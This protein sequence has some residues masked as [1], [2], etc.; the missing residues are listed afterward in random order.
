[1][2]TQ[3]ARRLF[4]GSGFNPRQNESQAVE[5][6]AEAYLISS[7]GDLVNG[8]FVN[9]GIAFGS[10]QLQT[11]STLSGN[12]TGRRT[13]C[14][15]SID[16]ILNGSVYEDQTFLDDLINSSNFIAKANNG[17]R[18]IKPKSYVEQGGWILLSPDGKISHYL[19]KP[20]EQ[21]DYSTG[22]YLNDQ[23]LKKYAG[24]Y[25]KKGW[26]VYAEF[27]THP[28]VGNTIDQP[29]I[30]LANTRKNPGFIISIDG[31]TFPYGPKRGFRGIGVPK[32]CK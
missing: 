17:V 8:F 9:V 29:D 31:K 26:Q 4:I 14:P 11:Q 32:G 15:P 2:L 1:M 5:S 28:D 6:R 13:V 7:G 16:E 19:I 22:V 20:T 25:L 24:D 3:G 30:N 10:P 23:E 27:H 12:N 18:T 21:Q